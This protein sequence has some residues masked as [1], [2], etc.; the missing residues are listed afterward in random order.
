LFKIA[1]AAKVFCAV[2]LK[3]TDGKMK[4]SFPDGEM[5]PYGNSD[6]VPVEIGFPVNRNT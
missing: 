2:A 1:F 4:L 6:G 3:P 5:N